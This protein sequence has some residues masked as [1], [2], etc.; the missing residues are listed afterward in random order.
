MGFEGF[1]AGK[2]KTTRIPDLFFSELLTQIDD[3][4]ELKVTLYVLHRIQHASPLRLLRRSE[5]LLDATLARGLVGQGRPLADALDDALRR[6]VTRGSLLR[7]DITGER[8]A[9]QLY[10]PNSESGRQL[11]Q[12]IESGLVQLPDGR[13]VE[14]FIAAA[15]RPS[16]YTLYEQNVG[17]LQPIIAEQLR[18]AEETYPNEWIAEAFK[19][20]V[21]SN[22]RN[23]RYIRA[24]LERWRLEGKSDEVDRRASQSDEFAEIRRRYGGYIRD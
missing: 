15:E 8:G 6:C 19:I 17:L 1:P 13:R 5:M 23:W 10:L 3:L 12:D 21:E 18:D 4:G 16:I 2:L 11:T 14:R 7:L 20:A 24:I 9:D 22:V